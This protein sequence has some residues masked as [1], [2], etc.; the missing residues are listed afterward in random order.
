LLA[1]KLFLTS[2]LSPLLQSSYGFI[3]YFDRRAAALAILS[4]NGRHL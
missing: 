1:C 4:L 2:L 3:H